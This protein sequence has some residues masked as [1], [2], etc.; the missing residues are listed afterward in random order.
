MA[1]SCRPIFTGHE[2][3]TTVSLQNKQFREKKHDDLMHSVAQGAGGGRETPGTMKD[4]S[5]ITPVR[6]S[7]QDSQASPGDREE[8]CEQASKAFSD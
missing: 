3:E 8:G 5:Q 1:E 4:R 7:S 2:S 6:S